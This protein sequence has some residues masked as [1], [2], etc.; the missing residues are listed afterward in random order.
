MQPNRVGLHTRPPCITM[1]PYCPLPSRVPSAFL[2]VCTPDQDQR[3]L[4][5]I[6]PQRFLEQSSGCLAFCDRPYDSCNKTK[7]HLAVHCSS[8]ETTTSPSCA[9]NDM[10]MPFRRPTLPPAYHRPTVRSCG[11]AVVQW[12]IQGFSSLLPLHPPP[13]RICV[14]L[15][16][17]WVAC[18]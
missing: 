15:S 8:R 18:C 14:I 10:T 11:H 9:R 12:A 7:S 5:P 2:S 13:L 4:L 17:R 6:K 3:H 1:P 16:P